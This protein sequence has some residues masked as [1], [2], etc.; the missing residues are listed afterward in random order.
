MKPIL[1]V[2]LS[3]FSFLIG[4]SQTGKLLNGKVVTGETALSSIDIVN[5]TSKKITKTDNNGNFVIMAKA[6]DELLI[7]SKEYTDQSIVVTQND[8][9]KNSLV[10]RLEDR[11]IELS[12][13][14]VTKAKSVKYKVSQGD[15]DKVKLEKQANTPKV[16]GVYDGSIENGVDFIR[17]GKGIVNLFKNKDTTEVKPPPPAFRDYMAANFSSDFY[18][19][20]LK[21][22]PDD[23]YLFVSF[24]EAD[25]KSKVV[26]AEQDP[27]K[28]TEFLLLK[29]EEFKK[30]ER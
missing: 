24:C 6:N 28:T 19:R 7:I 27:L 14:S 3:L 22:Q 21:I 15:L 9:E 26:A 1:I 20:K 18:T 5:V 13:V 30:L 8:L 10:V 11:P 17:L 23:V 4:F 29:K 2:I 25:P 16:V 12:E